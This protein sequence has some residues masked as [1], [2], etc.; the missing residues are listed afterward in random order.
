MESSK[1]FLGRMLYLVLGKMSKS[2]FKK[3]A[4]GN[5]EDSAVTMC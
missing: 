5:F 2:T 4:L 3:H 1:Y